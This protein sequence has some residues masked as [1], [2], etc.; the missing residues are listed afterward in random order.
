M[1]FHGIFLKF[2]AEKHISQLQEEGLIFCNPIK[3][4]ADLEQ[5][6][7]RGDVLEKATYIDNSN[8]ALL[9]LKPLDK[10]NAGYTTIKLSK[11]VFN[12][13]DAYGN[14]FCMYSINMNELNEG[15]NIK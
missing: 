9:K 1:N 7:I 11:F 10:P 4:F 12:R 15:E 5:D 14:L 13:E 8:D 6:E 3:Y 2:G